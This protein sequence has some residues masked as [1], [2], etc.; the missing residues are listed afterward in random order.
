[1]NFSIALIAKNESKTLPRLVES[2]KEFKARDGKIYLLDTGSTDGTAQIA[3]DLGCI[4]TEV[5][6]KF[7]ITLDA[8]TADSINHKFI[9]EGEEIIVKAGDKN[10]DYASARNYIAEIA[11]TDFVAMP[12]CDE[13]F[14]V[15]NLDA[16]EESINE[17][18]DQLEY[19]FVFAH[20]AAGA[21]LIKFQHSKF[22]NKQK[23]TWKG[24]IHE[25]LSGEANKVTLPESVIKLEHWQNPETDRN[26]YLTGLAID[27]YKH[28]ENDRNSH[29]FA[30][31]LMYKGR[32]RSAIKEFKRHI[33]MN[34]WATERAQSMIFIG[35]CYKYLND[36]LKMHAYYLKA[37]NLDPNRRE[38][39]MRIADYFYNQG[40]H[41]QTVAFAKAALEIKGYSFYGNNET[42]YT[43]Y[44]HELLY[45]GYW[46]LGE[47]EKAKEHFLKCLEYY[48]TNEKF[49]NEKSLFNLE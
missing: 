13:V 29:Y 21:P 2:L 14:T 20:D 22:Y 45:W 36:P 5:G 15:F 3:R 18:A 47:K 34:A 25:V 44:P 37:F 30:R 6:E 40:K 27:C 23:M 19:S 39:L 28:P 49:I 16:I 32:F 9:T 48:P 46:Y 12:D 35:D 42:Y 11:D 1:M 41:L 10:F 43:Y 38:S 26:H 17:G 4:V 7:L 24:I 33:E 8:D 31:E